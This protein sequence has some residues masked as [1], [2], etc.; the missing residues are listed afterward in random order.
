M[1]EIFIRHGVLSCFIRPGAERLRLRPVKRHALKRYAS[2]VRP[3]SLGHLSCICSAVAA[4]PQ[5]QCQE[6][7]TNSKNTTSALSPWRGPNFRILVYPPFLS[8]YFGAISSKSLVTT[9]SS[10]TY[11]KTCLLAWRSPRF[12]KVISFSASLPASFALQ[13]VVWILPSLNKSVTRFLSMDFL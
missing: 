4:A 9:V 10:K 8:S 1:C 12:A 7:Y 6:H 5:S 11:A 2:C 13:S 3:A